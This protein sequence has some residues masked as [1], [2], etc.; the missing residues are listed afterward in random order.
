MNPPTAISG[1]AISAALTQPQADQML[2]SHN[3]IRVS[4][5]LQPAPSPAL[6]PLTWSS[7]LQQHAQAWAETCPTG[8]NP[9]RTVDGLS[10]NTG[11]NI[12]FSTSARPASTVVTRWASEACDYDYASNTCLGQM[13]GHYTQLVWRATT[14]VGCGARS[15]C[16]GNFGVVVV[17][18]YWPAGNFVG[19]WPY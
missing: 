14:L 1:T 16:P 13:C 2:Q 9:D 15:G 17:C 12:Y 8:H 7:A 3:G 10:G 5:V 11:E 19:R 6:P 4:P 18:N